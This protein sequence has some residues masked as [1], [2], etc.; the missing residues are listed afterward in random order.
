MRPAAQVQVSI[1][2]HLVSVDELS[3]VKA[4]RGN[5]AEDEG[6]SSQCRGGDE[7]GMDSHMTWDD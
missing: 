6:V 2:A 3:N 5:S 4:E 1:V 7:S